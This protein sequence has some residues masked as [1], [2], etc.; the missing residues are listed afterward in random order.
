MKG[1][2][3]QFSSDGR[4]SAGM[5]DSA[6]LVCSQPKIH[7]AVPNSSVHPPL[8]WPSHNLCNIHPLPPRFS[9]SLT[10]FYFFFTFSKLVNESRLHVEFYLK[11]FQRSVHIFFLFLNLYGCFS[12]FFL[13]FFGFAFLKQR[14]RVLL[15][16]FIVEGHSPE[17]VDDAETEDVVSLKCAS[18]V[19]SFLVVVVVVFSL[20]KDASVIL[21]ILF[22]YYYFFKG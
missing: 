5:G 19:T 15:L 7:S 20:I 1:R 12:S 17:L 13:L 21:A 14:E 10:P 6:A 11:L 9:P 2:T 3:E 8:L 4:C 18:Q 22:F 16:E